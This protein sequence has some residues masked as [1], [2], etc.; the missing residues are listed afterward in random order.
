MKIKYDVATLSNIMKNLS[1]LTGISISLLDFEYKPLV[2]SEKTMDFCSSLQN[3][4]GKTNECSA[5]DKHLLQKCKSS[6]KLETHICHAGLYDFA[7]PIIKDDITVGYLI[8]GR[9]RSDLSPDSPKY[10]FDGSDTLYKNV[11]VFSDEQIHAFCHLMHNILFDTAIRIEHNN[12]LIDEITKYIDLTLNERVSI[13]SLCRRFHIYKNMLYSIFKKELGC[14]VN[15]YITKR[16]IDI[17]KSLLEKTTDA[18]YVIAGK[19]GIDNYTYFCKL[20]KK[21]TGICA[22]EY[23]KK[24]L[25]KE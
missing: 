2:N 20:F 23:R 3:A 8:M 13:A 9:I 11:R 10:D 4:L 1:I 21:H 12:E 17:A 25:Y 14:T 15:E 7:M 5:C 24:M 19:V 22:A 6:K 16:R 18:V